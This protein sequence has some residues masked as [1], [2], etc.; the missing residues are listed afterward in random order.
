MGGG[1]KYHYPKWVWS[2]AGGWWPKV[3]NANRNGAIY[4][5]TVLLISYCI[6]EYAKPRT[7]NKN[8]YIHLHFII[9]ISIIAIKFLNL[10]L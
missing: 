5:G 3:K 1:L 6:A 7:V 10:F 2:P 8:T 9:L 4:I